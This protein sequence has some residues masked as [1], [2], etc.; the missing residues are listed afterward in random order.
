LKEYANNGQFLKAAKRLDD[1]LD[2]RT[3]ILN[4]VIKLVNKIDV[5]WV[6]AHGDFNTK[7]YLG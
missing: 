6:D 3:E 4:H 7:K 5:V 1:I 2:G